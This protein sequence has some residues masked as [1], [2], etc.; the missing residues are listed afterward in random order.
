M[1]LLNFKI[2]YTLLPQLTTFDHLQLS[3]KV[4]SIGPHT[5]NLFQNIIKIKE[6]YSHGNAFAN[7]F[8]R[9]IKQKRRISA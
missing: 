7:M 6:R 4:Q 2:I 5:E 1:L 8:P 9:K 3:F